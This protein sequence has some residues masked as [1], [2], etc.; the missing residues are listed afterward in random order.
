MNPEIISTVQGYKTC[1]HFVF[2]GLNLREEGIIY[3]LNEIGC[4]GMKWTKTLLIIAFFLV[5]VLLFSCSADSSSPSFRVISE[6]RWKHSY[7]P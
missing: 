7:D 1:N 2:F 4:N 3:I 5:I 6:S